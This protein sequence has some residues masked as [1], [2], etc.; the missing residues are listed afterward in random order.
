MAKLAES[1]DPDTG[2][3]LERIREYC[4]LMA[5]ELANDESFRDQIDGEYVDLLYLTSPLHDIGKVGVPDKV[6]LKPGALTHEEFEIM[7]QHTV[8]GGQT[9]DT[10]GAAHPTARFL[11]MARDIAWT[12]HE[13]FDGRGYPRGLAGEDIPLCGRIVAVAD[14]YDALTTKRVYK[15]AFSHEAARKIIIEG[16]DSQFDPKTVSAFLQ[17]EDRFVE[18]HDHLESHEALLGQFGGVSPEPL[19]STCAGNLL[20]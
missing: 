12:H 3:H 2:A 6:L 7:K 17:T 20:D 19:V 18:V 16:S 5:E 15:P 14:V 4:R 11:E 8:I 9:L 13:R 1:R 10:V